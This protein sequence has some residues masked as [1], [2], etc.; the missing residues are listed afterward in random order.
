MSTVTWPLHGLLVDYLFANTP[1]YLMKKFRANDAVIELARDTPSVELASFVEAVD[2]DP[3]PDMHEVVAAYAAVV[4]LT[5]QASQQS[6][7]VL[8]NL[9]G[10]NLTW[11]PHIVSLWRQSRV[12]GTSFDTRLPIKPLEQ[13][14]IR[15]AA[16]S[17][18]TRACKPFRRDDFRYHA[19]D[20]VPTVIVRKDFD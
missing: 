9:R 5:L 11:I 14:Q 19:P 16:D 4:A 20:S 17:M 15:G 3:S 6:A 1:S 13:R 12:V 2:R 18:E 8:H 7:E 10:E